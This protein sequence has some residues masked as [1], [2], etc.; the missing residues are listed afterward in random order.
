MPTVLY[1]HALWA[2]RFLDDAAI[3]F[4]QFGLVIPLVAFAAG[5]VRQK[6]R[7]QLAVRLFVAALVAIAL[8]LI[9]GHAYSH[10]RPFVVLHL[11]PLLPHSPDNA[12]P[13][14]HSAV[15]AF[16]AAAL[17]FI[18]APMAVVATVAAGLIGVARVYC[19]LHWPNDIVGGW[20]IGALP[21]IVAMATAPTSQPRRVGS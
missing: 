9:A 14:D 3:A 10:P 15:A 20:I 21:A 12:F 17:F 8:D 2:H 11:T 16:I 19:L 6:L 18:D 4:A 7:A 13:S 1:F 5:S